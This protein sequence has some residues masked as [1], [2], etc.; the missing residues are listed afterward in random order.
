MIQTFL[1][2]GQNEIQK[3]IEKTL[4][5]SQQ[6]AEAKNVILFIG[7]GMGIS[8]VTS[9]RIYNAQ[10]KQLVG[11][12]VNLSFENFPHHALSKVIIMILYK[13]LS[14]VHNSKGNW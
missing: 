3:A 8:T 9:A 4:R 14:I 10:T 7:D 2:T 6:I 13:S 12:D 1:Q 11:E 5:I